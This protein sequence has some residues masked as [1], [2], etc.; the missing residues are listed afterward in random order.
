VR[1]VAWLAG[2]GTL[3][4]AAAYMVVSL[5]RWE[6]N[7]ALYFG[8]VVLIAEVGLAAAL[9]LRRLKRLESAQE[10]PVDPVV[11]DIL[12]AHRPPGR[13][14]FA[15]LRESPTRLNV[16]V[17]FLVGGGVLISGVAWVVDRVAART[18]S[19][20]REQRLARQLATIA[21]PREGLVVDEATALAQDVPG[22]DDAQVRTLL[23]GRGGRR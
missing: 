9:I 6:W 18:G 11:R 14:R 20:A 7:R 10:E 16:F 23:R 2:V 22:I 17:T 12:R 3:I 21:Y 5:Y 1:V 19:G 13:D 8:L 15:W 4:A